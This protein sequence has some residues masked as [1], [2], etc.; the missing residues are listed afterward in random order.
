MQR[1][2]REYWKEQLREYW[3]SGFTVSEYSELSVDRQLKWP[4]NRRLK[5]PEIWENEVE[6]FR[7]LPTPKTRLPRLPFTIKILNPKYNR[8]HNQNRTQKQ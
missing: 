7:R 3:G 1:H 5:W 6:A 8:Q 2:S 4:E